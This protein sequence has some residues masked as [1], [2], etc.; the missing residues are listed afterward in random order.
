MALRCSKL[1]AFLLAAFF[2]RAQQPNLINLGIDALDQI[3]IHNIT[4]G[5]NGKIWLSTGNGILSYDGYDIETH[6]PENSSSINQS[7]YS[8]TK[9]NLGNFY[10]VTFYGNIYKMHNGVFEEYYTIPDSFRGNFYQLSCT[11]DNR[12]IVVTKTS[13]I[14]NTDKSIEILAKSA[15]RYISS[16]TKHNN[17]FALLYITR[18][19]N[20]KSQANILVLDSNGHKIT[21]SSFPSVFE[22]NG[23]RYSPVIIYSNNGRI[24]GS[25]RIRKN[26][27]QNTSISE[28]RNGEW[29]QILLENQ[30]VVNNEDSRWAFIDN[31][32]WLIKHNAGAYV[33]DLNGKLVYGK[34]PVFPE[35]YITATFLDAEKNTW[36]G[37]EGEGLYKLT[38]SKSINFNNHPALQ[39]QEVTSLAKGYKDEILMGTREGH[40]YSFANK[41]LKLL[42]K[43]PKGT[44]FLEYRKD[45]NTLIISSDLF[46]RATMKKLAS[47]DQVHQV[48]WKAAVTPTVDY[49]STNNG[50]RIIDY[51]KTPLHFTKDKNWDI[52]EIRNTYRLT[53]DAKSKYLYHTT[54]SGIYKHHIDTEAIHPFVVRNE[55]VY[56]NPHAIDDQLYVFV[57]DKILI[58]ED[59]EIID[60][61]TKADG[62]DQNYAYAKVID[63]RL[64]MTSKD[65]F[66]CYDP[67]T[68]SF[69]LNIK[70]GSIATRLVDFETRGEEI[71]FTDRTVH[72][73]VLEELNKPLEIPSIIIDKIYVNN[74]LT[75]LSNHTFEPDENNVVF[76]Y[77]TDS[78]NHRGEIKYK[79][80][81]KGL[82]NEW[83]KINFGQNSI[84]YNGLTHGDYTFEIIAYNADNQASEPAT[85]SFKIKK[86]W[87]QTWWFRIALL[88]A[89]ASFF[90]IRYRNIR[91][92]LELER[93]RNLAEIKAI[94]AQMNPHFIFNCL[95][96][97]QSLVLQQKV[98][99]SYDYISK[100][101]QLVRSILHQSN[102]GEISIEEEIETLELYLDLERLRFQDDFSYSI[103]NNGLEEIEIPPLLVQ[104]FVENAIKHGLLHKDGSKK[105]SIIFEQQGEIVRCTIT[106]NGI[107]RVESNEIKARQN[108]QHKSFATET[109]NTRFELLQK[110]YGVEKLGVEYTD[111]QDGRNNS[112]GTKVV[113]TIPCKI[114]F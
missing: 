112:L 79:Y 37:S 31:Q 55:R 76:R 25:S 40:L 95:N 75:D 41:E 44:K 33:Y 8:L 60:S 104:P 93:D 58:L 62:L 78:Y 61:I 94:K 30:E 73:V 50:I 26:P 2:T 20:K 108:K 3:N 47:M 74:S 24:Y 98:S 34:D 7:F 67:K 10:A 1:I 69:T 106:D 64:Y 38:R 66:Q 18:D 65:G 102:A 107:G 53:Y 85:Y 22:K 109:T 91:K 54:K 101:A 72:K 110:Q 6:L 36:L 27:D 14:I 52:P 45:R 87:Y 17:G 35:I 51:S 13:F 43:Q 4:Q 9:D 82:T 103:E 80:R 39:G 81:L 15:S 113:L 77:F 48:Y 90:F 84:N 46:D 71:W 88:A 105:L 11:K 49:I 83:L 96:S 42:I 32:I 99:E 111:M 57:S 63:G 29:H 19:E 28:Y 23:K 70:N 97:I 86:H 59:D 5:D 92:R 100:F 68:K 16:L 89:V 114:P 12:L 21:K 56:T